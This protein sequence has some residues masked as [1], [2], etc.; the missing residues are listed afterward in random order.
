MLLTQLEALLDARVR[1]YLQEHGGNAQI[2]DCEN[3]ILRLRLTGRCAG[4]PAADLTNEAIIETEVKQAFPHIR[5][6]VLVQEVSPDL[7]AQAKSLMTRSL[8]TS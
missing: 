8:E 1:P 3:D 7:L 5:Q 6:V 4:C 2:I